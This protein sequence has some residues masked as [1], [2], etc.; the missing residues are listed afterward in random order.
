MA[1]TS[2]VTIADVITPTYVQSLVTDAT[3]G[4]TPLL[5]EVYAGLVT[6]QALAGDTVVAG[7]YKSFLPIDAPPFTVRGY[8]SAS[9]QD[10]EVIDVAVC[11][12]LGGFSTQDAKSSVSVESAF[13]QLE[14]QSFA[15]VL[16]NPH[17]LVLTV[18]T[19]VRNSQLH[20]IAYNVTV[21]S[22][23]EVGGIISKNTLQAGDRPA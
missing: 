5:L 3:D 12:S 4:R 14:S 6:L 1:T 13:A 9:T 23:L 2:S 11:V 19:R 10:L 15:S 22:P 21:F 7:I 8:G 17:C 20:R 16:G 18:N